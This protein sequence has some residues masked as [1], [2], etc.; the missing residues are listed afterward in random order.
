M[1]EK[2]DLRL[3]LRDQPRRTGSRTEREVTWQVP[4][5]WGTHVL[6]LTPGTTL[7]LTVAV[8]SVDEGVY[9]EVQ[10]NAKLAGE[11]VRCLDPTTVPVEINAGEL[12]MQTA[13]SNRSRT[14][15]SDEREDVEVEG[16]QLDPD[17]LIEQDSVDLEPMLRDALFGDVTLQP[18]CSED[19]EG[20]CEH[21]GIRWRDAEPGHSHEFI[22]PRF[23]SLQSLLDED[24]G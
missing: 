15:K 11:C 6:A 14:R 9:V 3:S 19:C 24:N 17:Y 10:G 12:Y 7:P 22:D 21:C 8:T 18:L 5:G 20:M 23:A 13:S 16:D 4:E 2:T 1:T